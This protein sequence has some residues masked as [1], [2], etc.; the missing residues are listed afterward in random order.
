MGGKM[1]VAIIG[2]GIFGITLALKFSRKG[3]EVIL[4]EKEKE[5]MTKVSM[6]NHFRHHYGYHYP[7]S[8]KTALESIKGRKTFEEEYGDCIIP[9]FPTYYSIVNKEEGTL[10]TPAQY[11]TFCE[12][13]NL[14]YKIIP[15]PEKI[16]NSKRIAMTLLVPERAFDPFELKK[17]CLDKLKNS[18]VD[19]RVNT[20]IVE[21]DVSSE[22]KI[23]K[24]KKVLREVP[25]KDFEYEK[26]F[27]C[28]INA[29]YANMN[30][31]KKA[32]GIPRDKRQYELL[33][34]IQIKIPGELFG[35]MNMDGEFTSV[36]PMG[37]NGL[38]TIAH[39]KGSVIKRI[40]SE[41]FDDQIESFGKFQSNKDKIME[42]AIN[43]FPILKKGKIIKSMFITK[44]VKINVDETDERH[45]EI[46]NHGNNIYSVF[47]GKVITCV[48]IAN[49][50]LEMA[51]LKNL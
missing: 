9:Y 47:A 11:L 39:A 10:T 35:A 46:F 48:D 18:E 2:A 41:D 21:G 37:K 38:Y 6:I 23:L 15:T 33:E 12:E 25:G 16:I 31:V 45:S 17:L 8:K 34:L 1:R 13:M 22:R 49:K 28:V 7:R 24:I 5:I 20:E 19:L 4:F 3:H 43:D 50:I 42:V 51:E 30:K 32:L 36:M 29:T 44:T 40:I 26:E 27:D 14:P